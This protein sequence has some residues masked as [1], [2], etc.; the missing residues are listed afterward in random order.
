[1]PGP[2]A[3]A[4]RPEPGQVYT[5]DVNRAAAKRRTTPWPPAGARAS[6]HRRRRLQPPAIEA[7]AARSHGQ[8]RACASQNSPQGVRPKPTFSRRGIS[9]CK[10][11]KAP[12][13]R[14]RR[15]RNRVGQSF[16]RWYGPKIARYTTT[17]S[18]G[19][20]AGLNLYQ[21]ARG[22]PLVFQ[23]PDGR[24]GKT[25]PISPLGPFTSCA[26]DVFSRAKDL[27]PKEGWRFAHCMAACELVKQCGA[28]QTTTKIAGFLNEVAQ[29]AR[30]I[31]GIIVDGVGT[32]ENSCHTAFAS[33]DFE[34][35]AIGFTCPDE[36]SCPSQCE[37]LRGQNKTP[38]EFGPF[39]GIPSYQL[40][41]GVAFPP[42][43]VR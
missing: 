33:R 12:G 11:L 36:R 30:C 34:D 27:G 23:D 31:K 14:P 5:A 10:S 20:S 6:V 25:G 7:S 4:A 43:R 24:I 39:F 17:D 19:L 38:T 42:V 2:S 21:Y 13:M 29:G 35:N 32:T 8:H 16:H 15:R 1:V 18:F 40:L 26:L 28:S 9:R 41:G 3:L 22:N 37:D